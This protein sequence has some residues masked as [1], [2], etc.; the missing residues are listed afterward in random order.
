MTC[1]KSDRIWGKKICFMRAKKERKKKRKREIERGRS[2]GLLELVVYRKKTNKQIL[3]IDLEAH[4]KRVDLVPTAGTRGS[5]GEGWSS[6]WMHRYTRTGMTWSRPI[7]P[8]VDQKKDY[9]GTTLDP[10]ADPRRDD[11]VPTV[12]SIGWPE[13]GW[14]VLDCWPGTGWHGPVCWIQKPIKRGT[15]WPW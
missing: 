2:G 9:L 3:I 8:E 11:L 15:I 13:V 7:D 4:Q 6:R 1:T 14:V 10:E 5:P 12:W